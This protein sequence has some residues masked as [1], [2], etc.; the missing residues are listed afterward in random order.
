MMKKASI[1]VCVDVPCGRRAAI[2]G[3]GASFFG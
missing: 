2:G 1:V 3:A